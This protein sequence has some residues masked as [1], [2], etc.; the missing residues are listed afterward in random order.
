MAV[1]P[2]V[3]PAA[4]RA[5]RA[6]NGML[7]RVFVCV[8][9]VL[10]VAFLA[11]PF[12]ALLLRVSPQQLVSRLG[13]R[14]VLD[15]L[16]VSL[17]SSALATAIAI[18]IGLP[19][20][21]LLATRDFVG[22]RVVEVLIDLP[23]VLPPTV[24]GFA[25]LMAFGRAG[26]IGRSLA[27]FGITL[28]FTTAGVVIA[29][30]FMAVPFFIGP[31]RA[32]FVGVD[33]KLLDAA[34]TLRASESFTFTRVMLPLAMPSIIAGIAMSGARALGEFGATITFAGN[35]PGTTQTMPLAVYVALQSDLDAAVVLS[36]LL[37][38]MAFGLLLGLRSAPTGW[39][40]NRARAQA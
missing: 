35:L 6:R 5:H 2:P 4:A 23:M 39:F 19:V 15:A 11:L 34:A 18:V 9:L 38:I 21:Y 12:V 13:S 32:G 40:W 27:V 1:A 29:Q 33:R 28:P 30:V 36:V 3:T 24:A 26:L 17:I 8:A 10:L 14:V 20:A 22:K 37:L 31:A 16:R 7:A 25:L